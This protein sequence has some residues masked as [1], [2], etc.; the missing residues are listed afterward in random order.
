VIELA[1]DG[2]HVRRK[3]RS[4]KP[5]VAVPW[6][7][8]PDCHSQPPSDTKSELALQIAYNCDD[9]KRA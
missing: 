8:E 2:R 5:D 1:L 7:N 4:T 3:L 9:G 6:T